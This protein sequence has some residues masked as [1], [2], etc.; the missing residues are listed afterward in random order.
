VAKKDENEI[1]HEVT[2]AVIKCP[3][4]GDRRTLQDLTYYK[5][6]VHHYCIDGRHAYDM[7]PKDR[8]FLGQSF[9]E[10]TPEQP[11]STWRQDFDK[12]READRKP[13]D[14]AWETKQGE[15]RQRRVKGGK[16]RFHV[17]KLFGNKRADYQHPDEDDEEKK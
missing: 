5:N 13:Q 12:S 7:D 17:D 3:L 16:W 8:V 6:R 15:P 14:S 2:G 9:S 4:C 1:L 10:K 11:S